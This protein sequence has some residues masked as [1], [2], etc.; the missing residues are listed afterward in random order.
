MTTEDENKTLTED[1][2]FAAMMA[3]N[4]LFESNKPQDPPASSDATNESGDGRTDTGV[5]AGDE[6][7]GQ[8]AAGAGADDGQGQSDGATDGD[9]AAAAAPA[10]A[11]ASEEPFPGY[12]TLSPEAR[13]A[14]DRL[15]EKHRKVENDYRALHGMTAPMQRQN[16]ELRR[17]HDAMSARIQQLEQLDRTNRDASAAKDEALNGLEEW[18]K[19]FPEESKVLMALVNP[20]RDKVTALEGQLTAARAELG[21]LAADR[22]QAALAR[23]IGELEKVHPDWRSIHDSPDYWEWLNRQAP[24]IQALNSSMFAGDTVQL[25]N[26]YKGSRTSAP[27]P[28]PSA[29]PQNGDADAIQQRRNQA[30]TRGTS[31]N[32]RGSESNA[33][34]AA[35]NQGPLSDEDAAFMALV[36]DNPL[37][38]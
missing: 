33:A 12:N 20:L 19:Q 3:G 24:G 38:R 21:T 2:Q 27:A 8:A 25:L 5:T 34:P 36:G 1:E 26:F 10:P 9:Q 28:A 13:E 4:P 32:V 30:L 18:A 22:Q 14:F 7:G 37:F 29:A 23:E 6:A 15:N 16:A 35:G 31:P 17:Q 11:P